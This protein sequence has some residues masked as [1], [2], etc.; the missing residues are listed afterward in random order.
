WHKLGVDMGL[1]SDDFDN[2][3]KP[4]LL[5]YALGTSPFDRSDSI[6]LPKLVSGNGT[7]S[8][9]YFR[10]SDDPNL[11]YT[12]ESCSDLSSDIWTEVGNATITSEAR[13]AYYDEVTHTMSIDSNENM[14]FRLKVT[15]P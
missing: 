8:L 10:R 4:N 6:V 11:L 9:S 3:G 7:V 15:T 5:E 13:D 2:D 1:A 14:F 12:I